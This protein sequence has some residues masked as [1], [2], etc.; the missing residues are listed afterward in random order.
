MKCVNLQQRDRFALASV[1]GYASTEEAGR[2]AAQHK[3]VATPRK[4][5]ASR[6]KKLAS[7][8]LRTRSATAASPLRCA[9][10]LSVL[11]LQL[12]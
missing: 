4:G 12:E 1:F 6:V 10:E 3:D 7:P 2:Q 11:Q 5:P 8:T 9:A